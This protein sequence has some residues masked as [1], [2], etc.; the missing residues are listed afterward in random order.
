M[1]ADIS[2]STSLYDTLGDETAKQY[3]GKCLA[4]FSLLMTVYTPF[5]SVFNDARA[6]LLLAIWASVAFF[7]MVWL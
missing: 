7:V 4:H 2:G 1:F 3:I 5:K 6:A